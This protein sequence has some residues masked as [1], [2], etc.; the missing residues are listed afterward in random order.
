MD[1]IARVVDDINVVAV[2][3]RHS[4]RAVAAVDPVGAIAAFDHVGKGGADDIFEA[5][6]YP[7]LAQRSDQG[8]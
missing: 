2:A 3:A 6:Q 7:N 1:I 8:N 5:A 4:I